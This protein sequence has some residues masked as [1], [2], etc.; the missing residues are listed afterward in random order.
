MNLLERLKEA[1]TDERDIEAV[2]Q[3]LPS[4]HR[5]SLPDGWSEICTSGPNGEEVYAKFKVRHG[6]IT[7]I[8]PG[9]ALKSPIAQ[10]QLVNRA[11]E[12][13]AHKHGTFVARRVLFS[14]L[15]LEGVYR[16]KDEL[17]LSPCPPACRIGK[18]LDW[19]QSAGPPPVPGSCQSPCHRGPPFPFLLEVRVHRSPNGFVE[20]NRLL[21]A[22]DKYQRLL[23]VLLAVPIQYE[24]WPQG[25]V[26]AMLDIDGQI[27]NHLVTPSFHLGLDAR[28]DDFSPCEPGSPV[29]HR[30]SD[31]YD[32]LWTQDRELLIPA[33]LGDDL[34]RFGSLPEDLARRFL[35]ACYWYALG[36]QFRS[37]RA[38]ATV[39]F[40]VAI[41]C[42]LPDVASRKCDS[43]GKPFGPGTTR[44]FK[45]HI[46]RYGRFPEPVSRET[47]EFYDIR[48]AL[49]HGR[50]ASRVDVDFFSAYDRGR[51]D[52]LLRAIAAKRCLIGWL[53][54]PERA[55]WHLQSI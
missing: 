42:L 1:V 25:P 34:D 14:E 55:T 8:V 47:H 2:L 43:C 30:C 33:T 36:I 23:T 21:R 39:A 13:T 16:F 7:A 26:W 46:D 4:V 19:F 41:E 28:G 12:D 31:Y 18:G 20:A 51:G 5:R 54:D 3:A 35:R 40:T 52:I 6:R 11:S 17:R 37:E 10:Q 44:L 32:R 27:E 9:P 29:I 48:S 50:F 22:L 15:P 45:R 49:V 24:Y 53:R 38:L